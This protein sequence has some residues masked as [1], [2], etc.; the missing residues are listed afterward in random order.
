MITNL[1]FVRFLIA[2]LLCLI[3][4]KAQQINQN[5]GANQA[6]S[7]SFVYKHVRITVTKKY[8][9]AGDLR[10]GKVIWRDGFGE[11]PNNFIIVGQTRFF[12]EYLFVRLNVGNLPES[13]SLYYTL[14]GE[15]AVGTTDFYLKEEGIFYFN[16]V[17]LETFLDRDFAAI[18]IQEFN[19]IT[20]AKRWITFEVDQRIKPGCHETGK[21]AEF[22][23]FI[24]KKGSIWV[25]GLSNKFCDMK[26]TFDD[27]D[28]SKFAIDVK[29]KNR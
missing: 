19:S 29:R 7:R 6:D 16:N 27:L 5:Q 12:D 14:T 13:A 15:I 9:V 3:N 1:N 8:I 2:I 24:S 25:F 28:V 26:V 22:F 21:G 18:A 4:V 20:K 11:N 10:T 17:Y 23:K